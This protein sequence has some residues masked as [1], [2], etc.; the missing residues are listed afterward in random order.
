M[1]FCYYSFSWFQAALVRRQAVL[2]SSTFFILPS[3]LACFF[4]PGRNGAI[5]QTGQRNERKKW[6]SEIEREWVGEVRRKS[7]WEMVSRHEY[8]RIVYHQ[9]NIFLS[10][11]EGFYSPP[12]SYP[13]TD[14]DIERKSLSTFWKK[15]LR[16]PQRL[17]DARNHV[18][19][20][21]RI[22][23][24]CYFSVVFEKYE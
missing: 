8:I 11:L 19:Q 14:Q 7:K 2:R 9:E 6:Y 10:L 20:V 23:R 3:P 17:R 12:S 22:K 24:E 5:R 18:T 1:L 21:Q 16:S 15:T 4:S 13:S